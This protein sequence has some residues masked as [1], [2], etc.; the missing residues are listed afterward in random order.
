MTIAGINSGTSITRILV[1]LSQITQN[2]DFEKI[3]QKIL[4][5]I[6]WKDSYK[7]TFILQNKDYLK[8]FEILER[9]WK[10]GTSPIRPLE[11][12]KKTNSG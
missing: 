12:I 8:I 2:K 4:L 5:G 3:A 7:N 1:T 6:P 11:K 10:K 9:N